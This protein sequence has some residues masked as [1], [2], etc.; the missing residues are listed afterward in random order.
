VIVDGTMD[1]GVDKSLAKLA[2]YRDNGAAEVHMIAYSCDTNE[3]EDRAY[4]RAKETGRKV[5]TESL[6]N[7]HIKVSTNFPVYLEKGNLDSVTVID[8]NRNDDGSKRPA[9]KIFEYKPSGGIKILN[10]ALYQ[11][12]LDKRNDSKKS[13]INPN[14]I[15]QEIREEIQRSE[16]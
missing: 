2:S 14:R 12:F 9:E 1:N 7:A 15:D 5:P 6:R 4:R 8:T 16:A 10:Q 11:R 3:A 13:G